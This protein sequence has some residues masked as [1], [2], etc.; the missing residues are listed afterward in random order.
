M[1]STI[2]FYITSNPN[3][4]ELLEFLTENQLQII[5]FKQYTHDI[6]ITAK[7]DSDHATLANFFDT[8]FDLKP[9]IIS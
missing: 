1:T 6:K 5:D 8:Y 9:K 2:E 4:I 7:I 3:S